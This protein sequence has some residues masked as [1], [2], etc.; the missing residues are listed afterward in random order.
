MISGIVCTKERT[1]QDFSCLSPRSASVA[2]RDSGLLVT[3]IRDRWLGTKIRDCWLLRFGI[4]GYQDSGSLVTK[5]RTRC[6]LSESFVSNASQ[7]LYVMNPNKF[8]ACEFL[9]RYHEQQRG[10]KIIVF[11]DNIFALREY[12]HALRKPFIYGPT[13]WVSMLMLSPFLP[14]K[15]FSGRVFKLPLIENFD[16][17][18]RQSEPGRSS[19][20][21]TAHVRD[22]QQRNSLA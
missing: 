14:S 19:S 7:A 6:H 16:N 4:A 21:V 10:D 18:G 1:L 2:Y 9:I 11:S 3:K 20:S 15:R 22:F 5:I 12:A 8:Q 13:R 17:S